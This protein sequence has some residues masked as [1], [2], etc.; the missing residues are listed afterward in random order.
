MQGI[1]VIYIHIFI[2]LSISRLQNNLCK[3]K[4]RT[5]IFKRLFCTEN[6]ICKKSDIQIQ[7]K[8]RFGVEN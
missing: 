8:L 3:S 4:S 2:F 1:S 6:T 5:H 7:I